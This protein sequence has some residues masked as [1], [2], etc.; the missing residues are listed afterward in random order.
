M[1]EAGGY[2]VWLK[3]SEEHVECAKVFWPVVARL[4]Q[5]NLYVHLPEFFRLARQSDDDPQKLATEL[6]TAE[7]KLH[8]ELAARAERTGDRPLALSHFKAAFSLAP[9]DEE[10]KKKVEEFEAVEKK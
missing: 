7:L 1:A 4:A 8:R 10:L 3:W 9:M 5:S 6:K 2:L